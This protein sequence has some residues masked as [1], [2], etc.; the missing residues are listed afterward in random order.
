M[1]THILIWWY[2]ENKSLTSV[3]KTVIGNGKN[4]IFLSV[5]NAWEMSIKIQKGTLQAKN[6][7]STYFTEGDFHILPVA[8]QHVMTVNSL[9][10]EHKDPFDRM[11]VAQALVEGCTLITSD[12]KLHAYRVPIL[13]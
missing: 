10:M 13:E 1:D 2:E 7:L 6:E 11:L 12:K 8:L 9:P 4:E 3:Q 5:V